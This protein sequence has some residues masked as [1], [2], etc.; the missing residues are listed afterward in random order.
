M[1]SERE[2]GIRSA[3]G[4]VYDFI[5]GRIQAGSL[6]PGDKVDRR[7]ISE[8]L[9]VS[10]SPVSEAML[11]LEQEGILTS[12]PRKGTFVSTMD[13]EFVNDQLIARIAIECQAARMYCGDKLRR[14]LD[15]MMAL[16]EDLEAGGL[17]G[18]AYPVKDTRFHRELVKLADSPALLGMYDLVM[19]QGLLLAAFSRPSAGFHGATDHRKLLALLAKSSPEKGERILRKA[20]L[21][22]KSF[23]GNAPKGKAE[24]FLI[25]ERDS[26]GESNVRGRLAESMDMLLSLE[27]SV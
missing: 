10:Y 18:M 22:G 4:K 9:D 21:D 27:T 13:D 3:T 23:S 6:R 11:Q 12:R 26:M 14:N 7:Q 16:A 1:K 19:R 20:I 5:V 2:G 25:Q 8:E 17:G 24:S 15:R